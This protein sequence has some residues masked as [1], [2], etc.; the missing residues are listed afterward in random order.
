MSTP[1][2]PICDHCG[3]PV[4]ITLGTFFFPEQRFCSTEC[5]EA[6]AEERRQNALSSM[7]QVERG[8]IDTA[9]RCRTWR[10]LDGN[11]SHI[12]EVTTK[13]DALRLLSLLAGNGRNAHV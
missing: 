9:G 5:L 7:Y 12:A 2:G 3:K 1:N 13:R 8:W 6:K 10:I 4:F 11:E